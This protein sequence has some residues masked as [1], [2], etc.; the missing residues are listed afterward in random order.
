M[1]LY[2][3]DAQNTEELGFKKGEKLDI[4][5]HPAHDPEWWMARNQLGQMGL[6]PTNY[7]E[8]ISFIN[9]KNCN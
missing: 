2:S 3:F 8:V 1:T 5:D 9:I 6:V 7:I 4:V